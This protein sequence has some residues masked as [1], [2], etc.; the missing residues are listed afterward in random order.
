MRY[1][2]LPA[3]VAS[4][5]LLLASCTSVTSVTP[6]P[7]GPDDNITIAG[8]GFGT[9]AAGD[10]VVYDGADLA[11]VS[12]ADTSI[13]ATVPANKPAG[14]YTLQVRKSGTLTAPVTVHVVTSFTL[15]NPVLTP[16]LQSVLSDTITFDTSLSATPEVQVNGPDG[17]WIVPAKGITSVE[18]GVHHKANILGLKLG[19]NYTFTLRATRN[20]TTLTNS[21]L[22]ATAGPLPSDMELP[23]LT[24][25]Q[26]NPALMQ[27]G[28]TM[29]TDNR[30]TGPIGVFITSTIWAVDASGAPVWYFRPTLQGVADVHLLASGDFAYVAGGQV[31]EFDMMGTVKAGWNGGA[32]GVTGFHHFMCELPNGNLASLG[33]EL[34]YIGPYPDGNTY[35]VVGDIVTE[36]TRAGQ[37]VH[38]T[39]LFDILDPYRIP[40]EP[41]FDTPSYDDIYHVTGTKDW[42]HANSIAYDPSDDTFIVSVNHQ[43]LVIKINRTTGAL[44]WVL[45]SDLPSTSGDD[46]WPYLTLLGP[47][48]L[49]NH[50]H[51][52]RILPGGELAIYDNGNTRPPDDKK[53]RAV[54]YQVNT[55]ARTMTQLWDWFDPDYN[56]PL[57]NVI[58]G[59]TDPL[60]GGTVLVG[61]S[62]QWDNYPVGIRWAQYAEVRQSDSAKVWE[63]VIRDPA[64]AESHTGFNLNRLPS[65]YTG[66]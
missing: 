37:V 48:D 28:F 23:P 45:G 65:L 53:S 30:G 2:L 14:T 35:P 16:N 29:F 58:G 49:T 63:M 3:L 26:S 8:S 56:P 64:A 40:D 17:S 38:K 44:V 21:S 10:G 32:M 7:A 57:L 4:V 39:S 59:D 41:S 66:P 6:D 18:P 19:A 54:I 27:P 43:D 24:I 34:R 60:S 9:K 11:I 33:T 22:S 12:W 36:F 52:V 1:R 51:S 13:V 5:S 47:G 62:A 46:N 42:T 61:N 50:Q 20:G 55:P 31:V 15:T 25:V